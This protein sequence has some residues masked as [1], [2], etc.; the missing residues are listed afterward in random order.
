M[1]SFK[2]SVEQS[3]GLVTAVAPHLGYEQSAEIAKE[4]QLNGEPVRQLILAKGLLSEEELNIIL[5]PFE[6][7]KPGIAAEELILEKKNDK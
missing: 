7:T 4:A 5:D 2:E 6:M 3:I 1:L